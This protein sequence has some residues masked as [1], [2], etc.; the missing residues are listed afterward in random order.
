MIIRT[1]TESPIEPTNTYSYWYDTINKQLKRFNLGEWS[2]I[3]STDSETISSAKN[4][5][6]DFAAFYTSKGIVDLDRKGYTVCRPYRNSPIVGRKREWSNKKIEIIIDPNDNSL[7]VP[8]IFP[9]GCEEC[10]AWLLSYNSMY[11]S[12]SDATTICLPG[13][14][15]KLQYSGSFPPQSPYTLFLIPVKIIGRAAFNEVYSV[16]QCFYIDFSKNIIKQFQLTNE[17]IFFYHNKTIVKFKNGNIVEGHIC[18]KL[19]EYR[20]TRLSNLFTSSNFI[21]LENRTYH[22]RIYL[23]HPTKKWEKFLTNNNWE[24]INRDVFGS[25]RKKYSALNPRLENWVSNIYCF[26]KN[27]LSPNKCCG[28]EETF[29]YKIKIKKIPSSGYKV[30]L[31]K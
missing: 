27:P 7:E 3:A 22:K 6:Y 12:S 20:Y 29:N 13:H 17:S 2:P 24:A 16:A 15:K 4:Y 21:P 1:I 26:H 19:I 8:S 23:K 5:A 28:K 18:D 25:S 9:I 14:I 10:D 31:L 30:Y 11:L